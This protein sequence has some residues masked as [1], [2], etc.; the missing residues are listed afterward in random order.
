VVGEAKVS[1]RQTVV[2]WVAL[3]AILA[4]VMLPLLLIGLKGG[5]LAG[6]AASEVAHPYLKR[7]VAG[8]QTPRRKLRDSRM[9]ASAFAAAFIIFN[10]GWIV[11]YGSL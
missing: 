2:V 5:W 3:L 4:V 11:V 1:R 9:M 10:L 8:V 7:K 6:L